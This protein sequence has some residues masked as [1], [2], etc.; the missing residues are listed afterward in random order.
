MGGDAHQ[1]A[2]RGL[3]RQAWRP[4]ENHKVK[5]VR[6][7]EEEKGSRGEGEEQRE[8]RGRVEKLI[9]VCRAIPLLVWHRQNWNILRPYVTLNQNVYPSLLLFSFFFFS[10]SAFF[11]LLHLFF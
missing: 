1:E 5:G 7:R 6:E 3:R 4:S 9:R 10:S 11:S 2:N 8:Q